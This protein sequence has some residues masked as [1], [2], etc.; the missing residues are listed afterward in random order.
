[1]VYTDIFIERYGWTG[2]VLTGL[3]LIAF[4]WQTGFFLRCLGRIPGYRS[5]RRRSR[6]DAEPPV[7][8]VV[9]L[10]SENVGYVDNTL[11]LLL[12]QEHPQF[13]IVVV[14]VGC[15]SDFYADLTAHQNRYKN[16]TVTKI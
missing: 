3:V 2:L 7:S 1:M 9:P 6:L 14:Y 10:F 4:V 16:L 15:D 13:Q 8:V 12:A 5:S 11:P